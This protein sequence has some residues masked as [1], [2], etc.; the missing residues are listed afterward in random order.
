MFAPTRKTC[1]LPG[2][3]TIWPAT[4]SCRQ[5]SRL[6][7]LLTRGLQERSHASGRTNNLKVSNST[8]GGE[9][10]LGIMRYVSVLSV[11]VGCY[12]VTEG[13]RRYNRRRHMREWQESSGEVLSCSI[14]YRP[15]KNIF[16]V[17][18]NQSW[19]ASSHGAEDLPYMPGLFLC[20]EYEYHTGGLAGVGTRRAGFKSIRLTRDAFDK[21]HSLGLTDGS[22]TAGGSE[23]VLKAL[24]ERARLVWQVCSS[25][26]SIRVRYDKGEPTIS[27]PILVIPRVATSRVIQEDIET[28][29]L[30]NVRKG[31]LVQEKPEE[32]P[33]STETSST[34]DHRRNGT[35][36]N[37]VLLLSSLGSD[38]EK[39][40]PMLAAAAVGGMQETQANNSTDEVFVSDAEISPALMALSGAGLVLCAS[41][42][43]F[44]HRLLRR[45]KKN[46]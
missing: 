11:A 42:R 39:E 22:P 4:M 41:T 5:C 23:F 36:G 24:T 29:I 44:L 19:K 31:N 27:D 16:S 3:Q 32:A 37:G 20:V 10:V 7:G 17:G 8:G 1:V 40:Q 25:L 12:G 35:T 45:L 18:T 14:E 26:P 2:G 28:V 43:I 30:L 34:V 38:N 15:R 21:R 46:H 9:K 33:C 6:V 13:V